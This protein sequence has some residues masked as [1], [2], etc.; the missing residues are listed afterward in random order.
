MM[1]KFYNYKIQITKSTYLD[2]N[3]F[4]NVDNN[5]QYPFFFK[6]KKNKELY[7]ILHGTPEGEFRIGGDNVFYDD[8]ERMYK[9]VVFMNSKEKFLNILCCY[10]S[11]FPKKTDPKGITMNI[12]LESKFEI[13]TQFNKEVKNN[14]NQYNLYIATKD[15]LN[16]G[17]SKDIEYIGESEGI[18]GPIY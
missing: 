15:K 3:R 1:D 12:P 14:K 11:C 17:L 10:G 6:S 7:V 8:F 2:G 16:I 18:D 5:M 9:S 13:Y 4:R